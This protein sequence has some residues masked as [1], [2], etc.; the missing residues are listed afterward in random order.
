MAVRRESVVL[1]LETNFPP[2]AA[3]AAAAITML[4]DRVKGVNKSSGEASKANREMAKSV[5]EVERSTKSGGKEIDQ[6]SGRLRLIGEAAAVLGPS[7]A[8]I[9]A[10]AVPAISGLASQM[11]FAALAG[12]TMIA[13][14]QGVGTALTAVNKAG[15]EPT[16]TNIEAARVAMEKIGPSAQAFVKELASLGPQLSAIQETAGAGM[17]PG[18]TEGITALQKRLPDVQRIVGAVAGELGDI[19]AAAGKS[20]ASAR[21]DDF[22]RFLADEAPHALGDMAKATGNVV[23]ALSELWMATTPMNNDFGSWM[24]RVTGELDKWAMGLSKTQGFADFIDYVRTNGPQVAATFGAIANMVLQIVEAA[25]PLG[26]TVLKGLEAVANVIGSIADSDLGTPIFT[27]LAALVLYNR[28]LQATAALSK[29]AFFGGAGGKGAASATGVVTT[30]RQ[31]LSGIR[32]DYKA[33]R[34]SQ[35]SMRETTSGMVSVPLLK[36]GTAES[37]RLKTSLSG[38]GMAAGKAGLL[39][40]GL[41]LA[42][43]GAADSMGVTNTAS[44]AMMGMMAGPWGAAVG[45]GAGAVIDLTH[46][47]DGLTDSLSRLKAMVGTTDFKAFNSQ[48]AAAKSQIDDMKHTSG[49]GDFFSDIAKGTANTLSGKGWTTGGQ[50]RNSESEVAQAKAAQRAAAAARESAAAQALSARGYSLTAAGAR[51]AAAGINGFTQAATRANAAITKQG[52]LD[53]Y[54]SSLLAFNDSLK[55]NGRTLANNTSKGLANRAALRQIA[56]SALTAAEG[57][58]RID[59]RDGF[60]E[61]ARAG[62]IRSAVAAGQTRAAARRLADQFGLVDRIRASPKVK[63]Q[64]SLAARE[65][66]ARL[67]A[68]IAALRGKTVTADERGSSAAAARIRGLQAQI[69]A[70]RSKTV[71]VTT[72]NVTRTVSIHENVNGGAGGHRLADGGT[73]PKT[74]LPYA[75][76]HLYLLADGE[77]VI[78]NRYG[79]VDRHKDLLDAINANRMADGGTTGLGS[80]RASIAAESQPGAYYGRSGGSY[81]G[82]SVAGVAPI[83]V[84][85]VGARFTADMGD[86][87]EVVGEVVAE[88]LDADAQMTSMRERTAP[89]YG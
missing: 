83:H 84:S 58:K 27:A 36:Q 51:E 21:W 6:Y 33:A 85:L 44:L 70:L 24:V 77:R 60:L 53:A 46:S 16:A 81:G 15:L 25:A 2:E 10:V 34:A 50:I 55:Q 7:I 74:G 57:L 76:R 56:S 28:A 20:L 31:Q 65:R 67:Q 54:A 88:H 48:V 42:T 38:M 62:F 32:S 41:A 79:Q 40:G 59:V 12:G 35:A 71:T 14:F 49:V 86:L 39:V 82:G 1:E 30:R 87:G 61:K 68:Q 4:N 64:G 26:G 13:A 8:P 3:R 89:A 22:F 37:E 11:G 73:V 47:N 80:L 18:F 5:D 75:D 66:I 29:T 17:F 19:G 63:E 43:S 72:N 69:N 9:G 52:N 78:S 45:A 23:H